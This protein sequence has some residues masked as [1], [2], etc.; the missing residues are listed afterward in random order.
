MTVEEI[1]KHIKES[2]DNINFVSDGYHT[3]GELYDHRITLFITLCTALHRSRDMENQDEKRTPW[4]S[5]KHSDGSS[6]D[7]WFIAG[8]GF[9]K[10][11]QITYHL[12]ADRWDELTVLTLN[13]APEYDGHTA[14]DVI[15]RLKNFYI[16]TTTE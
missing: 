3:F 2:G 6:F 13:Q 11:T 8:I 15:K 1:N 5:W 12:P 16:W 9:E 14:A 7:G 4:K 10:G